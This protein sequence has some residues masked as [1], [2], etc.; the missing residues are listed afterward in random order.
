MRGDVRVDSRQNII[1]RSVF[2]AFI[3]EFVRD[4]LEAY[5]YANYSILSAYYEIKARYATSILGPLWIVLSNSI[6]I[7]AISLLYS[8]IFQIQIEDYVPFLAAGYLLWT[9][10]VSIFLD[11]S[12]TFIVHGPMLRDNKISP[13]IVYCRIYFRSLIIFAHNL[14]VII[15]VVL[16]YRGFVF[17]IPML[18]LGALLFLTCSFFIGLALSIM[19][20]RFRD[21]HYVMPSVFQVLILMMPI[22]WKA[23]MITGRKMILIEVNIFY[24]LL[25]IV[26]APL[27]G[28]AAPAYYYVGCAV[29][30]VLS[31]ILS[32]YM[33]VNSKH[34]LV[35][36]S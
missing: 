12:S 9:L 13:L 2:F 7:A 22:L 28:Y 1:A 15:A 20:C 24:Q 14:P 18:F 31:F 34:K 36:W 32:A 35:L 25:E 30:L 19:S 33:Y 5:S 3:A 26:R 8:S 16:Y 29:L 11:G 6:F 21:I 4:L 10:M 23:D 27:L 17:D